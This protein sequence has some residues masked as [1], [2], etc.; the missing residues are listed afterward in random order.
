MWNKIFQWFGNGK[1]M[2]AGVLLLVAGM[3]GQSFSQKTL[4]QIPFILMASGLMCFV[5]VLFS[6]ISKHNINILI[7]L[8]INIAALET[9]LSLTSYQM[10]GSDTAVDSM[11]MALIWIACLVVVWIL[12]IFL[13]RIPG[14]SV[15]IAMAA[16]E[17][18]VSVIAVC[19][20]FIVPI[21]LS[22]IM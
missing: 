17:T 12:Q 8:L 10:P 15:R 9:A 4:A 14:W 11:T 19:V 7:F 22:V 2:L 13:L 5:N 3:I 16:G 1:K 18:V 21:I 20:A 6:K